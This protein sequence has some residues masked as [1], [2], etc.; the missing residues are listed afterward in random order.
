M[1]IQFLNNDDDDDDAGNDDNYE[2]VKMYNIIQKPLV[3]C[4]TDFHLHLQNG[5]LEVV[6]KLDSIVLVS[7]AE[8]DQL[9]PVISRCQ[10]N[11]VLVI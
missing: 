9:F 11:A 1:K 10:T 2:Y 3:I 7:S 5:F 4:R 6:D 8:G